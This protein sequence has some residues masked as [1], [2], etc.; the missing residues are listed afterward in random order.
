MAGPYRILLADG[1]TLFRQ[2]VKKI[3]QPT[4]GLEV[5]GEVEDSAALGVLLAQARPDLVIIDISLPHIRAMQATRL[6]KDNNPMVKVLILVMDHD[7]EY[8]LYARRA[9][10]DGVLLKQYTAAELLRAIKT[11]RAGKFYLPP[12]LREKKSYEVTTWKNWR[13]NLIEEATSR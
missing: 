1:H 11:V 13:G 2:E 6:I 7:E 10:A 12:Q 3:I 8:L 9:G 5:V 4:P